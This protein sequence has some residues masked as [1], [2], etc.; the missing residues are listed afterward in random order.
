MRV[1]IGYDSHRFAPG[2]RLVLGG[3]EIPSERGLSGHSDADVVAHAITDALL[4]AAALGD[5]G[6]HFPPSDPR[7][8]DADSLEL[9]AQVRRWLTE[10]GYRV[11]N[12]DVTIVCE[13]PRLGP[14]I[15]EMRARLAATLEIET[16]RI[17]I[18]A[19]TNEGMGWIGRGEGVAALAVAVLHVRGG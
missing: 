13:A 2:R 16:E 11:G 10:R 1:G 5:I 19:K 6:T 18:K 4:G 9:L 17:S 14:F 12:V 3:I 15:A 7:W 8:K